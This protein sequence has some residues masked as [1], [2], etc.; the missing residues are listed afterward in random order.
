MKAA[1][2][3]AQAAVEAAEAE[4]AAA[5]EAA[6]AEAEAQKA[7]MAEKVGCSR[8]NHRDLLH[9]LTNERMYPGMNRS[10]N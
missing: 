2:E 4:A 3:E 5:V 7:A 9:P 6:E 10:L 1:L 8:S